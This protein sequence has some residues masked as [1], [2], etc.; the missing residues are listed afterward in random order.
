MGTPSDAS[1]NV[2]MPALCRLLTSFSRH[3]ALQVVSGRIYIAN[4][5]QA[6][7]RSMLQ[8]LGVTHVVN[9]SR[10]ETTPF[11]ESFQY[12]NCG[13][14]D[15]VETDISSVLEVTYWFIS[16]AL[17]ESP[18]S[19][20][21]V[22][23]SR[24]VSRSVAI[25]AGYLMRTFAL[26]FTESIGRIRQSHPAAEPNNGIRSPPLYSPPPCAFLALMLLAV[27]SL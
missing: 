20:V 7:N 12:C 24:G 16:A 5:E 15:S 14:P 1:H 3:F 21:L 8:S 25:V 2:H 23:C 26:S 10:D 19:V 13:L 11:P 17:E 18:E 22:H 27:L 4:R 6:R 9:A